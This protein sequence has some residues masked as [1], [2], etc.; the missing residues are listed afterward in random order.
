MVE[1]WLSGDD[2]GF[3]SQTQAGL[4]ALLVVAVFVIYVVLGSCTR[5]H[6]SAHDLSGLPLR[7]GALLTSSIFGIDFSVYALSE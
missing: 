1:Y 6:P 2:A 5:V 7:R 4:L 3:A